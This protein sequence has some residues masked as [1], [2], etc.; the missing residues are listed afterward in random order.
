MTKM[1]HFKLMYFTNT[2]CKI[3]KTAPI[4]H[5]WTSILLFPGHTQ[6]GQWKGLSVAGNI[7]QETLAVERA[8]FCIFH[9]A[10]IKETP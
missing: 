2:I 1:I 10:D 3:Q 5:I 4:G 8:F 6:A 7:R 9:S